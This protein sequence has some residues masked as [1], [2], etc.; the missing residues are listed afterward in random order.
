LQL[1]VPWALFQRPTAEDDP[2][3]ARLFGD[4]RGPRLAPALRAMLDAQLESWLGVWEVQRVEQG[5]G[6]AMKDL[7]TGEE[8]FVHEI[9]GS[10]GV[11]ARD[12]L[13]G[14]VVTTGDISF[15]AGLHP[16]PLA[17]RHADIVVREVRRACRVRTRPVRAEKLR[18]I[19]VQLLT[20]D[21]WRECA[22]RLREPRP[23]P[24][25]TNTDG[26]SI[27][28]TIDRFDILAPNDAAV[29]SRLATFPGAEE[30]EHVANE[31]TVIAI[32]KPGNATM[33]SWE[34]TVI[35][36]IVI[37]LAGCGSNPTPRAAWRDRPSIRHTARAQGDR[38]RD[39][40]TAHDGMAGRGDPRARRT[41]PKRGI[42][43]A[44]CEKGSRSAVA[45]GGESGG[46]AAGGRAVRRATTPF[47]A[48]S[49]GVEYE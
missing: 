41:K 22:A 29:V 4:E 8:R 30:P 15:L 10:R 47:G 38:K 28:M 17:P 1:A 3:V 44:T 16:Q 34:N 2:P 5:V 48:W 24:A 18:E 6:M 20:I 25:L 40:G 21:L 37:A 42:E 32:T 46:A 11:G 45:R 26:D 43:V 49:S 23:M 36:R 7:L 39:E 27:V 33:K 12:A 35:G 14:R 9:G 13:L 19:A 31:G